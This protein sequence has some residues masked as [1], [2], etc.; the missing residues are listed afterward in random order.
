M[1][2]LPGDT[3]NASEPTP[4]EASHARVVAVRGGRVEVRED[5][6]S[7]EE[8]LAIRACGPGQDPIDVAVTMRT[9]GHEDELATGSC[10][11][12]G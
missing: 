9:P 8:P 3:P 7:G 10:G 2:S 4:R 11:R 1:T 12:K 5:R 6:L